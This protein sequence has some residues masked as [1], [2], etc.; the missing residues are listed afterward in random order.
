MLVHMCFCAVVFVCVCA[1]AL[2]CVCSCLGK[3]VWGNV[4]AC[5]CLCVQFCCSYGNTLNSLVIPT[6]LIRKL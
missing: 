3:R 2:A 1:S 6:T 5:V 4:C